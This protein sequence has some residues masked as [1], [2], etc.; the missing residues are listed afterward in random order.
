MSGLLTDV[1][2]NVFTESSS[3]LEN[4]NISTKVIVQNIIVNTH[5]ATKF[6]RVCEMKTFL[7]ISRLDP[8]KQSLPFGEI[9]TNV[10]TKILKN[11]KTQTR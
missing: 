6:S 3:V 4:F 5:E 9:I 2:L 10:T 1:L 11:T 7:E 8:L